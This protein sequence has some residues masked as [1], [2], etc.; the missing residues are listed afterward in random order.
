MATVDPDRRTYVL[1]HGGG[2]GG[3]A[4]KPVARLL[5]AAGHDV[6][7]PTLSG[8]AERSG[9]SHAALTLQS[10]IDEIAGLLSWEDLIDVVL[11]AHSYGGFVVTG[12]ADATPERISTLVYLDAFVPDD[13]QS[14]TS[15]LGEDHVVLS[16]V[17]PDGVSLIMP[18]LPPAGL[19]EARRAWLAAQSYCHPAATV[20][21]PIRL[22]GQADR[23]AR[24]VYVRA[25]GWK[26]PGGSD[27]FQAYYDRAVDRPDWDAE[28]LD[29]GH[30]LMLEA[31]EAVADLLLRYA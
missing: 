21:E 4:W 30:D 20:R 5:R 8:L 12:V 24:K 19:S 6:Y 31:P 1:V 28:S 26:G 2:Y 11:V 22:T 10:H 18:I 15:I 14:L 29:V 25:T 13:G 16:R 3:W 27:P 17:S 9:A 7:A 23:I